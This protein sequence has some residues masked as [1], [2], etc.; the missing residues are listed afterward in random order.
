MQSI[1]GKENQDYATQA[2]E[3]L[4]SATYEQA[5][6]VYDAIFKD[7]NIANDVVAYIG[8]HDRYFFAQIILNLGNILKRSWHPWL[9][10]RCREVEANT[11]G[12]IDL[13]AREHFKSTYITFAG[14][15]QEVAKDPELTIGIFSHNAK[16]SRSNFIVRIK[17]ELETNQL[18]PVYY[19]YAFFSDP[20]KDSPIWSRNEGLVCKRKSNPA[21]PTFSGHG[22]VDGQPIGAHFGLM[23]YDDVVTDK[24]VGTPEMITKTTEMWDLSQF[25]GK[26]SETGDEKPRVWYIGTRYNHADTYKTILDR[27]VAKPRIYPATDTGAPDGKPVYLTQSQWDEKKRRS[28]NYMVACQMLQ[29]PLAGSEIEFKPEYIRRYEVRPEVLNVAILID[30]ASSKKKG[31]SDTAMIVIGMDAQWNKYLLDGA[32]HKMSLS[33]KWTMMKNLRAKWIRQPGIQ[34][35]TIGYEKYAHQSDVEHYNQMMI[36]EQNSFPIETVSW[37]R[38]MVEGS[39]R[40]RIRRLLPD[41]QNWKFF[42]PYEGDETAL[43]KRHK[44]MGKSHLL[45]KPIVRRNEDG[46]TYNLTSYIINSE[47]MFFP[48]LVKMDGLDAMSRFYD[49]NIMPPMVHEE[50]DIYPEHVGDD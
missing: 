16:H 27:G 8:L 18:L 38:D 48:A 11:D 1:A 15:L 13:W 50:G 26:E 47:M 19:P 45:S 29:N 20:K 35:V 9:Y 17:T 23:I 32:I 12:Y 10:E 14:A 42:Y 43:Q 7:K 24:S 40:D 44:L 5:L 46:R 33:E 31:S 4:P 41:H 6:R 49:L 21:E 25:L 28:S 39:K 2:V 36:I 30:P 37:P 22:L 34:V 3:Y